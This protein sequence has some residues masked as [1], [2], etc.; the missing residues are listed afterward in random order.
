MCSTGFHCS[1]R[2]WQRC[3][4]NRQFPRPMP[5]MKKFIM[6]LLL[7]ACAA[8]REDRSR[9]SDQMAQ[10]MEPTNQ[11]IT[12]EPVNIDLRV[13]FQDGF[14]KNSDEERARRLVEK[15]L[16]SEKTLQ[17][18]DDY[19]LATCISL[20]FPGSCLTLLF[21]LLSW[22]CICCVHVPRC[23]HL[24]NAYRHL[25]PRVSFAAQVLKQVQIVLGQ[26]C[27]VYGVHLG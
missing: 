9:A 8:R 20:G 13:T 2:T 15:C 27:H 7:L 23:I 14:D 16:N 5:D 25:S 22:V 17:K 6:A 12:S 1:S 24:Q 3:L 19:S 26:C 21:L 10:E 18:D 11:A 4:Q